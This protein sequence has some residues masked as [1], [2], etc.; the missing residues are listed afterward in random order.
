MDFQKV[1]GFNPSEGHIY[2]SGDDLTG[3]NISSRLSKHYHARITL[4][5]F[6]KD[7]FDYILIDEV[8]KAGA[9]SYK[10]LWAILHRIFI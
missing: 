5:A 1:L 7:F 6:S 10:K 4:K 8:H 3:K 9:D 2:H